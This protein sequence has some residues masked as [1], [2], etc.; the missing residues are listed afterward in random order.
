MADN[1]LTGI[2]LVGGGSRR[3]GSPKA[4]E[5]FRG[6]TLAERAWHVLGEVCE[7]RIAV[8]KEED[9][10]ELPFPV[11]DDGTS[12]RAPVYGL[13]AGLRAASHDVCIA[14]PVD[15]PLVSADV[16]RSLAEG[17]AV[18]QTGPLPG[19]YERAHIAELER[20][21]AAGERSLRG[22]NA[23]I[24]ETDEKLL[25][26]VNTR[27]DLLAVRIADWARERTDVHAAVIV[28]SQARAET[29]ADRWSD[30]D[31]ILVVEEPNAY[32]D[33]L[34]WV[35]AF[36]AP[37]LT[38]VEPTAV[39]NERELRVLFETGEDLDLPLIPMSR[40]D[41]LTEDETIAEVL[42]RG[43]RVL[44]DDIGLEERLRAASLGPRQRREPTQRDLRELASD[45]WYHALWAAK[46]LRRGEVFV[47]TECLDGYL[48]ARLVRL[49]EWHA[50][51]VDLTVDTWHGGRFL[52]R[53]GDPGALVALEF[54]YARYSLPDAARA[55]WVTVDLWQGLEEETAKRLGLAL[56]LDHA[57][58]RRR[59]AAVVPDPRAH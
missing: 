42:G 59:I 57:D 6:E 43:Y 53:W 15:C 45:F 34:S 52:E 13:L 30:L 5:V 27:S 46:K 23:R 51:A 26:N 8:G 36:G 29:A 2:L 25:A 47:A 54:A 56:E 39:G 1:G 28:G 4:L 35:M 40:L 9:R 20:R 18:P 11:L 37:L 22:V 38:F 50:R 33:D 21:L 17:V 32:L 10:L 44:V 58:L 7:E 16:L 55:L 41:L 48:K 24:V 14:L 3:F 19:A 12:E 49:L 31:V